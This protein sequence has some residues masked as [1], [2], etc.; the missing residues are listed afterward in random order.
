MTAMSSIAVADGASTPVTHT[1]NPE[2]DSP[3]TWNDTDAAKAYKHLQYS[4]IVQRT[5]AK[6]ANGVHR[7]KVSLQLPVGGDGVTTP[8]NEVARFG[9]ATLEFLMPAKGT[10]QE[11]KDL[12]VIAANLLSNA[13]L[14]DMIDELNSAW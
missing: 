3:P 1:M 6:T 13:Q 4:L 14:I 9:S 7:V 12:R 8:V 2:T 5:K 11:R 10:K